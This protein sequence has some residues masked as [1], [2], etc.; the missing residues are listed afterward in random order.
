MT[1]VKEKLNE[2]R[3]LIRANTENGIFKIN[4]SNMTEEEYFKKVRDL[5]IDIRKLELADE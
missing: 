1:Q 4:E 3:D 5:R 2:L